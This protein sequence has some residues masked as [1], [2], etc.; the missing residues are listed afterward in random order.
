MVLTVTDS[1]V[2]ISEDVRR[3]AF[4]PFFTTKAPG[5]GT[6]LGLATCYGIVKQHGGDIVL[7]SEVG[8]GTSV[9]VY[10]PQAQGSTVAQ[11]PRP[12][13]EPLP[14]G[15]ETV[16]LVEDEAPV[17]ALAARM[18]RSHGYTILEAANG[19]EALEL[20]ASQASAGLT[21]L[22]TDL[23]M[24]QIDGFELALKLQGQLPALR[25]LLMSGSIDHEM[26]V[27]E[28][29]TQDHAFIQK[30]FTTA[31]LVRKVREVIDA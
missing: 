26:T 19:T 16:L 6:G 24:P 29:P 13:D 20:A 17:R 12:D 2:G 22:L 9:K 25:V 10:L 18:L 3:H 15:S 27:G 31:S 8:Q 5:K 23:M 28:L 4:E 11:L 7:H 1:G 21:L 30:P 14:R